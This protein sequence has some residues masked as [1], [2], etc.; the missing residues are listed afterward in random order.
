M[1]KLLRRLQEELGLAYMFITHD[2]GTVRRIAHRTAVMLRGEIIAQGP[3]A[4]IFSPPFHPYTEKLISSVPEMDTTWLDHVLAG[5]VGG[6]TLHR[7][8][9]RSRT[10]SSR[11]PTACGS[12]R[13]SG[14]PTRDRAPAILEY[15]PYRKRDGTRGRDEPMH[16][17][18][19][20]HGY[21]AVRVD[22]RGSGESD[23]LLD[24]EYLQRELDD[25]CEVIAWIAAQPWCD[26]AVGMMGKSW[27]GFNA[28]QVA[29]LRP[30]ALKAI[31]TV[32]ST[33]DRYA[34]DIHYMGG[35]LLNDN[36][37]WG[38]IMLA[39]QA[40]PPDP[41]LARRLA[42][43][44]GCERLDAMPFWPALWLRHQRRDAYWRHGSVCE[45]FSAIQCPVFAVGG[46]ADAYTNAVPRLLEG[47]KVPRLGLI[48]PWAHLYP[49]DGKPGPAI[50]FLQEAMRWWDHWL[51]GRD[52]GVMN[53]PMLRAFIEERRRPANREP[54]PAA[55]SARRT[56][57]SPRH[58]AAA[59]QRRLTAASTGR[60][61]SAD[62]R[63][64]LARLDRR[65]RR[66]M[67]GH[68][69]AAR[70]AG[71]PAPRR[72]LLALLRQRAA[73]RAPGDPRRAG[74]RGRD[75]LRQAG[76]AAL[77][78][79]LR[80]RARRRV[81]ARLLRRAQ[82]HASRQPRRAEPADARRRSIACKLKLNDCGYAFAPGHRLRLA[83]STRLLAADLAGAGTRDADAASARDADAAG[84]ARPPTRPPSPSRRA[85]PP[86]TR[87][88]PSLP[89]A[90]SSGASVS[91]SAPASRPTRPSPRAACSA[92]APMRFDEI[93]TSVSHDLRRR[94]T[95]AA[96]DPLSARYRLDQTYEMGRDGWRIRIETDVEM[97]ATATHF[98]LEAELAAFENGDLA[99]RRRFAE[100]IPRDLL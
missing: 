87:P 22:M 41:A 2:L 29:A 80:R 68:R 61:R 16:G 56:W 4:Q 71:G 51:K 63:R 85:K 18:F 67:D 13:A 66:R 89:K 48:G 36:L 11:S 46:W 8:R 55:S 99:R 12:P 90:A 78:A 42:R 98:L 39:Y 64:L 32:C 95:I 6:L 24:D 49:H 88:R 19:A 7:M 93:D 45:D 84:A 72:R 54:P 94:F 38:A 82:P 65:G 86:A 23:G 79:A 15:I 3:T 43:A 91:I 60:A 96:D 57:P 35:A 92:R 75:R 9:V 70:G 25:A 62:D 97:R 76:R 14:C 28:L 26:G 1:L 74:V 17:Y 69:R 100:T 10:S 44:S 30:P 33:D 47:L 37:W 53:E 20:A 52:S 21:A 40:R 27:G 31:I 34:D 59:P 77:R 58:R 81:A 83:L 73:D 50:G 5:R